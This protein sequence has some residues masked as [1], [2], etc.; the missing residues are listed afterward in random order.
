MRID[1]SVVAEDTH[2]VRDR[3][4]KLAVDEA[5]RDGDVAFFHEREIRIYTHILHA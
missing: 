5:R 1:R 4:V 2:G 3:L